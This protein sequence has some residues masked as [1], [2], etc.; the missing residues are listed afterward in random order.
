MIP[1]H[2]AGPGFLSLL[3]SFIRLRGASLQISR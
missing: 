1:E 2:V 3:H